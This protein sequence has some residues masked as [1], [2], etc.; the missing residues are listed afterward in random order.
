MNKVFYPLRRPDPWL[1]LVKIDEDCLMGGMVSCTIY[2]NP[3]STEIEVDPGL[4][5]GGRQI[6]AYVRLADVKAGVWAYVGWV[7]GGYEVINAQCEV[8]IEEEP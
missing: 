2:G 7:N 4:E 5:E 6:Q 8:E 3:F 1:M